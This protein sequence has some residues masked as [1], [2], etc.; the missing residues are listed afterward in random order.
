MR[1]VLHQMNENQI[2]FS[3]FSAKTPISAFLETLC[4]VC[5]I[6]AQMFYAE[7]NYD[8][9]GVCQIIDGE[10]SA[11]R[12]NSFEEGFYVH[13]NEDF[14]DLVIAMVIEG[15]FEDEDDL[16]S[17][18]SFLTDADFKRLKSTIEVTK[19]YLKRA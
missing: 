19:K 17:N 8:Y 1:Q 18:Y 12:Y 16:E 3:C 10:F 13:K 14:W 11:S 6:N 7:P 4:E 9:A 15:A 5:T 2:H